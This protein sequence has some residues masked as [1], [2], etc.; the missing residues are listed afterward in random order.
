[1]KTGFHER[2]VSDMYVGGVLW[3]F[4]IWA[5]RREQKRACMW[6]QIPVT[7]SKS[8]YRDDGAQQR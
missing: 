7:I 5:S 2:M 4:E 3:R 6:E 8:W 1:M